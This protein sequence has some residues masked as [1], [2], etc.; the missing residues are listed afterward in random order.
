[1][2]AL[3]DTLWH[4]DVEIETPGWHLDVLEAR[5][6]LIASGEAKFL[7]LEELQARRDF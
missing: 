5:K 1:M 2:E 3:W 4:E 7:S 6:A